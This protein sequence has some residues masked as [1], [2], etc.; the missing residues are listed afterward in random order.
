MENIVLNVKINE[1]LTN[2]L[3]YEQKKSYLASFPITLTN[4]NNL[5]LTIEMDC[6]HILN[7]LTT[8]VEMRKLRLYQ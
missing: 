2:A 1:T 7:T 6:S 4:L 8:T 3:T 5:I